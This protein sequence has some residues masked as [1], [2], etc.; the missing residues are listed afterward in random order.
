M[1]SHNNYVTFDG[2]NTTE[3]IKA[4]AKKPGG[5]KPGFITLVDGQLYLVKIESGGYR[6]KIIGSDEEAGIVES[7]TAQLIRKIWGDIFAA[8]IR[9]ITLTGI[10]N[11]NSL[12][13]P[14]SIDEASK[15]CE[16][17]NLESFDLNQINAITIE[18]SKA[19]YATI[20]PYEVKSANFE[21]SLRA[22]NKEVIINDKIM[23]QLTALQTIAKLLDIHDYKF[24]NML[25]DNAMSHLKL[26]DCAAAFHTSKNFD[27]VDQLNLSSLELRELFSCRNHGEV[28]L[29]NC[30]SSLQSEVKFNFNH[31][32]VKW[33]I[34]TF[35]KFSNENLIEF[36]NNYKKIL[37]DNTLYNIKTSLDCIKMKLLKQINQIKQA[38]NG[39]KLSEA[40]F[41]NNRPT[42]TKEEN[43]THKQSESSKLILNPNQI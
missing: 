6:N 10:S 35:L 15:Y 31:N 26:I 20:A 28:D 8:D 23:N 41:I 18:C 36:L 33:V 43:S 22:N 27:N 32:I 21:Q 37:S 12:V 39:T 38:Q 30:F 7:L 11:L 9:L 17:Y 25:S 14:L 24:E 3:N 42:A 34:S 13:I 5:S 1:F 16:G 40:S 4:I 19:N 29:N 2:I